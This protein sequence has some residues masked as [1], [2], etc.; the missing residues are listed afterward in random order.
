MRECG[1]SMTGI[2]PIKDKIIHPNLYEKDDTYA[3]VKRSFISF[4]FS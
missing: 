2:F 1:F 4:L 3:K